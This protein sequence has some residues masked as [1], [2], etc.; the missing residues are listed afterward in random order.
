[1]AGPGGREV[2]RI[3]IRVLPDTSKFG[4]ELKAYVEALEARTRVEIP[5]SL[6]QGDVARAEAQLDALTR[7]RKV[8]VD[9][10]AFVRNVGSATSFGVQRMQ[11]LAGAVTGVAVAI[12]ALVAALPAMIAI[13]GAPL[14]AAILGWDGIK[15]AAKG[16]TDEV[17]HLKGVLSA[18]FETG[19][20]PVFERLSLLFPTLESG[21][22]GVAESVIGIFGK[23]SK[24]LTSPGGLA[25]LESIFANVKLFFD[26][27]APAAK[28]FVDSLLILADAGAK[29][30]A[31]L[32]PEFVQLFKDFAA[33]LQQMS[34]S[35][36]LQ[37]GMEGIGHALYII[38]AA[39]GAI[40][41][42]GIAFFA[43]M[44]M[45]GEAIT[46]FVTVTL[47]AAWAA[48]VASTAA[49]W[50]SFVATIQGWGNAAINY[51]LA[52]PFRIV[53]ALA[54]LPGQLANLAAQAGAAFL[55]ALTAP[56]TNAIALG[57]QT[58][59]AIIDAMADLAGSLGSLGANAASAFLDG[60]AGPFDEAIALAGD[61]ASKIASTIAGALDINSPSKVM[62]G[63]GESVGEGL[64]VGM[65][66]SLAGVTAHATVLANA[67]IQAPSVRGLV[68]DTPAAAA[69]IPT[70]LYLQSGKL[71]IINGDAYITGVV[72]RN[73]L[74]AVLR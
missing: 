67:A 12:G 59:Q 45:I 2:G 57:V 23:I 64:E 51:A 56:F 41:L 24:A 70:K 19:L 16:L 27:I 49:A 25:H 18:T 30:A 9:T 47:P 28:P 29:V 74:P 32:T 1:M 37:K 10:D 53:E 6:E 50:A 60:L 33:Q 69:A 43:A 36:D 35:G 65:R 21:L 38:A 26:G 34:A 13:F 39:L 68:S 17:E 15:A 55:A 48:L 4:P 54:S 40:V 11:L 63:I 46:T 52:L 62:I 71:E 31:A 14:A 8:N 58:A 66:R 61:V 5:V 20:I 7:D 73:V 22:K 44:E 3:S 42:G 72:E